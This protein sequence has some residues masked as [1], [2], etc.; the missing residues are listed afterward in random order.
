MIGV[1]ERRY[2]DRLALEI[3]DRL[4]L[5]R[6]FRRGNDGEQRQLSGDRKA[7]DIG[8]DIDIGL[9]GDV[10]SGGCIV[11]RAADQR[12]HRRIA[13]AGIDELHVEAAV[14]EVPVGAGDFIR[15]PA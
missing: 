6:G 7:T 13:A 5:A 14:L 8:A 11:D 10:Q 9:H 1:A 3:L 12:L 15:H 4:N 2:A